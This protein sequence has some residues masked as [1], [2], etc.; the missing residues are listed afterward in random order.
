MAV[1]LTLNDLRKRQA[2]DGSIDVVIETL[3]Q[4]NPILEDVRWAEGNR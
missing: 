4:S 2:P 3:V 1:A